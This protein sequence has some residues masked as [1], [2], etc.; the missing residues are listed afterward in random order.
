MSKRIWTEEQKKYIIEQYC[1]NGKNLEEIAKEFGA[2]GNTISKYL[3]DWGIDIK[4]KGCTNNRRLN[5]EYFSKIDAPQKAYFLGLLFTDGSIVLDEKRSPNICI[6]LVENDI[7]I[8]HKF[9]NELNSDGNFYYNKRDNRK[10]GTYSFTVRSKQLAHDLGKY[11]I[12]PNK[13]YQADNLIIPDKY[14]EEF[15]RGFIEGDGSIYYSNSAWHINVC[16]HSNNIIKEV[17]ELGNSLIGIEKLKK[18]SCSN[19]VYRYSWD[20]KQAIQLCKIL[21]KEGQVFT[22]PRKQ[23]KALLAIAS[24]KL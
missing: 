21:Y 20:G 1:K 17:A 23:E 6:E 2:K 4:P 5:H 11:N 3:K 18:I 22:I 14:K 8:L 13:T 9:K 12:I 15:F 24:Q 19:G 7:S 16:G 10:N